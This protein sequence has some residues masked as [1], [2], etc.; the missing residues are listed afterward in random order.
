LVLT[1]LVKSAESSL[2]AGQLQRDTLHSTWTRVSGVVPWTVCV[3]DCQ[4]VHGD[5]T[6]SHTHTTHTKHTKYASYFLVTNEVV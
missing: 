5:V 1:E 6:A 4:V 2:A 3:R